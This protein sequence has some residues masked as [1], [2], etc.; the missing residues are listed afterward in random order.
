MNRDETIRS[1]NRLKPF[2]NE[3][4]VTRVRFF[5]AR[6]RDEA[7]SDS[8]LDLIVEFAPGRTPDLWSFVGMGLELGD[9][10]GVKV[11]LFTPDALHPALRGR[12]EDAAVEL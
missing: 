4:G 12:I 6:A 11:D 2:L 8:D 9:R 7:R 3:R 10:L 5:G 1:L